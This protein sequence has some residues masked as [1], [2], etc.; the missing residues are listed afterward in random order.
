[1]AVGFVEFAV[2][3]ARLSVIVVD[4]GGVD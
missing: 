2:R 1:M 4:A 3:D